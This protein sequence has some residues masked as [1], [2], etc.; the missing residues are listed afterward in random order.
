METGENYYKNSIIRMIH[1]ID[2]RL[3]TF[4]AV[5][6]KKSFS[7]AALDLHMTQSTVSQHIQNLESQCGVK[8]FDRLHRR[9]TLTSAG[10]LLYPYAAEIEQLYQAAD[11]AMAEAS[12]QVNGRLHIGASLT[13]GEYLM[14]EILIAFRRLFTNV[15][16]VMEIFNTAQI[17][18]L[19]SEGKVDIGFIE[20]PTDISPVVNTILCSGDELVIIAPPSLESADHTPLSIEQILDSSWVMREKTSGT[21]RTFESYLTSWGYDPSTLDVVM[22]LGSTQAVKEAVK[23]GLGVAAISHLAVWKD[24]ARGELS[25]LQPVEGPMRRKFTMLYHQDKFRSGCVEK[26]IDFISE[27]LSPA[28]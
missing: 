28:T 21:R 26:F 7:Q 11:K 10:E 27:R 17:A 12:G 23:A 19:V 14:P 24:I 3:Q 25:I 1:V 15:D 4:K 6:D 9:I 18:S 13:I 5:A 20:G 8:L 22:E 2:I 16:I